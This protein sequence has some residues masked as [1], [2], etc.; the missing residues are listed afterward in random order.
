MDIKITNNN[1]YSFKFSTD[2]NNQYLYNN[3]KNND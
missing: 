3:T 2:T 1:I